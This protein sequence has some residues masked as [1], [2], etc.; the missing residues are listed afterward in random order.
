MQLIIS[1]P[2]DST[3]LLKLGQKVDFD[4]PFFESKKSKDVMIPVSKKL[5]VNST[6]IFNHL[7]K[8]VGDSITKG[9]LIAQKKGFLG[10]KS[11]VSEHDGFIREVNHNDGSLLIT[12]YS[13]TESQSKTYFKG[14]VVD[15]KKDQLILEVGDAKEFIVKNANDNF[16]GEMLYMKSVDQPMSAL[17]LTNKIIFTEAL[18][19]Y[20]RTKSEALGVKGFVSLKNPP[21]SGINFHAQLKHSE[22]FS[23]IMNSG[24]PYCVVD[25]QYSKIFVYR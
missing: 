17:E 5:G 21:E 12:A 9:E 6:K 8:F 19:P 10:D 15:V 14:E 23:K 3:C 24:F 7:K 13:S 20:L 22:D 4:K 16:G 2:K 18:T 1:I 25:K 11:V